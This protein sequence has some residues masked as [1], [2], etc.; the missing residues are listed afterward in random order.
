IDQLKEVYIDGE[1]ETIDTVQW[2]PKLMR[3]DYTVGL[4]VSA[5]GL[6]DPD[7][8]F[9]ENYVCNAE[10]N[11]NGYCNPELDALVDHQSI[12]T[13]PDKRRALVWAIERKLAEDVARPISF[14][15][16]LQAA[17]SPMSKG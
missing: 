4:G 5:S 12:E 1:L 10:R 14:T 11:D 8:Q 17:G 9:Y 3:K 13:D 6:D 16:V 15:R 2:Y 7:Q